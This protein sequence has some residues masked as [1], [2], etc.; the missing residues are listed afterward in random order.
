MIMGVHMEEA[1]ISFLIRGH[2]LLCY[3]FHEAG[4][5]VHGHTE[6]LETAPW[7][8]VDHFPTGQICWKIS[9]LARSYPPV[10]ASLSNC[11]SSSS[12]EHI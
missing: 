4:I 6:G 7:Q 8:N 1:I 12:T 10:K 3:S 11:I 9:P 2:D 5:N